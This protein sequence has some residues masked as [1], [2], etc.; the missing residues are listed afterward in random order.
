V[1]DKSPRQA[2]KQEKQRRR[3]AAATP[4]KGEKRAVESPVDVAA[5]DRE[6]RFRF[7]RVDIGSEWC[8]T[9]ISKDDHAEL[10]AF[11]AEME[12][13]KVK[14]LIP[15][16]CKHADVAADSQNPTA[17]KRAR[18]RFSDDHDAIHEFRISGAKRLWGLLYDNEFSIIWWDPNHVVFP[19]K[20]VWDN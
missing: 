16:P 2:A 9:D 18:E 8:L 17:Q 4:A 10:I 3:A 6:L 14:E 19:S 7:D 12:T 15:R 20:R 1:G 13:K 11:M 5:Y